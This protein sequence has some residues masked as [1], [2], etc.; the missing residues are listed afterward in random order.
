MGEVFA[1]VKSAQRVVIKVGTSTLTHEN[2]KINLRTIDCLVRVLSD[3]RGQGK[4]IVFVT[5]GA[6]GAGIGKLAWEKRPETIPEKQAV[7]A[8]GQCE[9]MYLYDKLFSEYGH[10][11]AQILLTKDV[12]E[13]KHR[14][15]NAINTFNKLLELGVIPI[16]NEND[17]IAIEEI[18]YADNFGDNDTLSA[19]VSKLIGADLLIILSDIDGLYD[20]DPK[21]NCN[22]KIIPI[23]KK[24]DKNIEKVAGGAGTKLGTGGMI[25]KIAAAEI[26]CNAGVNMII[27]KGDDPRILYDI[28]EGKQVGTLFIRNK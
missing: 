21:V 28:F 26:A 7:A 11:I 3:L 14:K 10:I 27:T 22:A 9:L 18:E 15:K 23:V 24:V 5:S 8:I 12:I 2:G 4:D 20:D 17:T 25:T 6:I 1:E 19:V 13:N 16:V